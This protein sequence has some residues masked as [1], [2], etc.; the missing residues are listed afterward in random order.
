MYQIPSADVDVLF[1]SGGVKGSK[2]GDGVKGDRVRKASD[3]CNIRT[4][5]LQETCIICCD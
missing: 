2:P 3:Q 5:H 4:C 1:V